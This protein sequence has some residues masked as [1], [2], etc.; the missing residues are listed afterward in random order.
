MNINI[1]ELKECICKVLGND[2]DSIENLEMEDSFELIGL[3]SIQFIALIV[4]LEERYE[5]EFD[6]D[7]LIYAR[8][9]T[10]NKLISIMRKYER[11]SY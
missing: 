8:A 11:R 3:D 6:D 2:A 1:N 10:L 4:M 9:N 7:D 5:I